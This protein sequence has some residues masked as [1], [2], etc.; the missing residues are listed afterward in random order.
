MIN[1]TYIVKMPTSS[2]TA[3][4][5]IFVQSNPGSQSVPVKP[6]FDSAYYE[7]G[8]RTLRFEQLALLSTG[9]ANPAFSPLGRLG[10]QVSI[11]QILGAVAGVAPGM[12]L[13]A[14]FGAL[15]STDGGP[16]V[17]IPALP[18]DVSNGPMIRLVGSSATAG[19]YFMVNLLIAE[20]KDE[21]RSSSGST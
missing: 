1:R 10:I 19:H 7:I 3:N 18:D 9:A 17:N 21:N 20:D 12:Q 16:T 4:F 13:S 14:S 15:A 11:T 8:G 5:D 6:A 2:P